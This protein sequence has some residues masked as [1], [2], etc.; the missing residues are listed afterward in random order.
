VMRD[1]IVTY[2]RDASPGRKPR[3]VELIEHMV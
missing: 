1:G 3:Q 2:R